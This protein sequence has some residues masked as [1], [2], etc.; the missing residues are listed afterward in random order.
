MN[1]LVKAPGR[2][3]NKVVFV[4]DSPCVTCAKLMVQAQVSHVYYR[5]AYRDSGGLKVLQVAGVV[6]ILYDRWKDEWRTDGAV[7]RVIENASWGR[8][9]SGPCPTA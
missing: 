2:L 9:M 1:A 7:D 5:R 8:S 6:P 4:T 3:R